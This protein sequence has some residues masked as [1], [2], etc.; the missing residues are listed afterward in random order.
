VKN[1]DVNAQDP[2][3]LVHLVLAGSSMPSTQTAP[4][5]LAMPD[6]GWRLTDAEV[7]DV[8]GFVRG[9]WGNHAAAVGRNEVSRVRKSLGIQ[10]GHP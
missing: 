10:M 4:S 8:L 1:E 2:I 6:L 9:N 5:A 7:A 3:S